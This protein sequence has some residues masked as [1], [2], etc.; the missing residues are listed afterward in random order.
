MSLCGNSIGGSRNQQVKM[1]NYGIELSYQPIGDQLSYRDLDEAVFG[2]M[3]T[4]NS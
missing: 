1:C 4:G 3:L 2:K